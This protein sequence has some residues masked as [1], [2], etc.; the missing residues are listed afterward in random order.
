MKFRNY[1]VSI[2][3]PNQHYQKSQDR[4]LKDFKMNLFENFD[5]DNVTKTKFS[6]KNLLE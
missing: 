1:Y 4:I 3:H 5:T 2:V 6:I